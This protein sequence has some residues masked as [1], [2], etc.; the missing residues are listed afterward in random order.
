MWTMCG[1]C[2]V[3]QWTSV[4]SAVQAAAAERTSSGHGASRWL[5]SR[6]D[7]T[8]SHPAKSSGSS[9][10]APMNVASPHTL[11]PISGNRRTS[12]SSA[13]NGS[14]IAGRGS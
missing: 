6:S 13:T 2:D 14:T 7:T 8:T 11:V 12:L 3:A 1:I 4:P 9:G 5:T 10:G